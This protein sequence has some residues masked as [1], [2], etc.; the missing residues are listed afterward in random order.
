MSQPV[1]INNTYTAA[2]K[3]LNPFHKHLTVVNSSVST[4]Q[5]T[6]DASL[7][8][9]FLQ[10]PQKHTTA[11]YSS[12]VQTSSEAAIFRPSSLGM[13][14]IKMNH[15]CSMPPPGLQVQEDLASPVVQITQ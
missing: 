11:C 9:S 13:N 14:E 5:P 8:L 10:T 7:P 6:V 3:H 12:L 2:F 1:C 4:W 15:A